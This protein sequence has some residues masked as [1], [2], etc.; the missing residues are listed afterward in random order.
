MKIV[1]EDY[2]YLKVK[3]GFRGTKKT[4]EEKAYVDTGFCFP[5]YSYSII[6]LSLPSRYKD[7]FNRYR[8]EFG[9]KELVRE[10]R[11]ADGSIKENDPYCIGWIQIDGITRISYISIGGEECFIGRIDEFMVCFDRGRRIVIET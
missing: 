11:L 7:V 2:P 10:V 9:Q 1:S 4:Y 6:L 8:E 3:F 5:G